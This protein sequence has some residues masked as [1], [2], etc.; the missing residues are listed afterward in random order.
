MT[1][2]DRGIRIV[3]STPFAS[4]A[5]G[6]GHGGHRHRSEDVVAPPADRITEGLLDT[7]RVQAM[8]PPTPLVDGLLYLDTIAMMYG[9]SGVGKSFVALD[10]AMHVSHGAWWQQRQVAGGEVLYIIA[11]G[12]AGFGPRLKAWQQHNR[13]YSAG[14]IAWLPWPVNVG[15]LGW[16]A[17]LAEVVAERK[18][19]LVVLD[20]LARCI[21][22]V[23]EN[24]ARDMGRVVANLETVRAAAGSCVLVVH[25]SGKAAE[26]GARGN[27]ALRGAVHTELEVTGEARRLTLKVR[28]Q[29]DAVVAKPWHF[30]LGPVPGTDSVALTACSPEEGN[31]EMPA[32]APDV[33]AALADI[34]VEEGVSATSWKAS[35]EGISERTFYR[36]RKALLEKGIVR[37]V[38]TG[39]RPRYRPVARMVFTERD[40]MGG[41]G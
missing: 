36:S 9:P 1:D 4:G 12:A 25:H 7:E 32:K 37:N 22:G 8:V 26:A 15:D 17:A 27:S 24:S 13:T 5:P 21:V 19:V 20:T 10:L 6:N 23:E 39:G 30:K 40:P 35:C 28:K 14:A 11:E 41:D 31:D 3:R 16:T 33:L 34:D 29:K 2:D 18:P 38:G